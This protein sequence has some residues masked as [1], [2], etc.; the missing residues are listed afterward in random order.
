[1]RDHLSTS[2]IEAYVLCA[3]ERVEV[4]AIEAHLT[5][6]ERCRASLADQAQIEMELFRLAAAVIFCKGCHR[7]VRAE[8][9]SA[10]G[11]AA[12]V[13]GYRIESVI[14][15]NAHGR[16]YVARSP[17]GDRVA[18]KELAFVQVPRLEDLEA[19]E[20]E[21]R[22]LKTLDHPGIPRFVAAFREGEGVDTRLYMA[23]EFI[24]GESLQARM[25]T[26]Q[27]DE[28]EAVAIC[29]QVLEILVY[30]Q[31]LSPMVFHRDIK[32]ANL[33][34]RL[35]G[36]IAL[37]D[38]GAARNLGSTIGATLV[39]TFGYMPVEQL[40]GIVDATSDLYGLGATLW[41][42]LS[43]REPWHLL[44]EEPAAKALNVSSA[45]AAFLERLV[46]R[47]S[48][49]R[50]PSA[51]AASAA[52]E[53]VRRRRPKTPMRTRWIPERVRTQWPLWTAVVSAAIAAGAYGVHVG[54]RSAPIAQPSERASLPN[55]FSLPT[56]PPTAPSTPPPEPYFVPSHVLTDTSP[57]VVRGA[58]SVGEV[59]VVVRAHTA[60]LNTCHL[61]AKLSSPGPQRG[62]A[63][64]QFKIAATGRVV[65]AAIASSTVAAPEFE[66]C[67]TS[68]VRKWRF[69]KPEGGGIVIVQYPIDFPIEQ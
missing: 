67:V 21:T 52:L 20:R 6:C 22:I 27:F 40:T 69:P 58:L 65:S 62:Q 33:I 48:S 38:F 4:D 64:V 14:V 45:F 31:S 46:A 23:Q 56:A 1:M 2:E 8:R 50:F 32:P 68:A 3:C 41:H 57:V 15:Q 39:G 47:R 43:R 35:D 10:C 51:E 36:T 55:P 59:E 66:T 60:D 54:M 5:S 13:D 16:V 18:L 34:R 17:Q 12:E 63:V 49:K 7:V 44:E 37:V 24:E 29:G 9:C 25:A 26:H 53:L 28:A 61:W 42:L 30:L 11:V 19:F